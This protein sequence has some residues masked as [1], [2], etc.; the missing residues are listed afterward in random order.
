LLPERLE[1]RRQESEDDDDDAC[2]NGLQPWTE[3]IAGCHI[4]FGEQLVVKRGTLGIV[5]CSGSDGNTV[6][7]KFSH[8]EDE[9]QLCLNIFPNYLQKP[10]PGNFSLDQRVVALVNMHVLLQGSE[11]IVGKDVL[12]VPLGTCGTIM[13]SHDE[14]RVIVLFDERLDAPHGPICVPTAQIRVHRCLV[15]GFFVAQRVYAASALVVNEAVRVPLGGCGVVLDE[16]SDTRLTVCFED[17]SGGHVSLNLLPGELRPW[18]KSLQELPL[19]KCV[20]ITEHLTLPVDEPGEYLV[21]SDVAVGPALSREPEDIAMLPIGTVMKILEIV[22]CPE[23]KRVRARI[24]KPAGWISLINLDEED[25]FDRWAYRIAIS[26]GSYGRVIGGASDAVVVVALQN[27]D[28][29]A[30]PKECAVACH[31]LRKVDENELVAS[32]LWKLLLRTLLA[33]KAKDQQYQ[34][35]LARADHKPRGENLAPQSYCGASVSADMDVN[36]EDTTLGTCGHGGHL[37]T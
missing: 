32:Y 17:T 4:T 2:P 26:A 1:Q 3:V 24:E 31:M 23:D 35:D 25:I 16:F 30:V 9:S 22:P 14:E 18:Y 28:E 20:Q 11:N 13:A 34:P 21:I 33:E 15:G 27:G 6:V 8:R 19:G 5:V 10:L 36:R 37:P 12:A 29:F 7:V